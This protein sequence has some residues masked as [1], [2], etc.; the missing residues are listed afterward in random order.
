MLELG[1]QKSMSPLTRAPLT[2][3]RVA[4][5][6]ILLL[7]A[8]VGRAQPVADC[9]GEADA[10]KRL[11]CYDRLFRSPA[12]CRWTEG[13]NAQDKCAPNA[14]FHVS[15]PPIVPFC[16]GRMS[17]PAA[18]LCQGERHLYHPRKRATDGSCLGSGDRP[19]GV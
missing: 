9:V 11:A 4:T 15:P 2:R 1:M 5:A 19:G 16:C 8:G 6:V 7:A 13:G 18:V 3:H 17:N 14:S 10:G 12:A